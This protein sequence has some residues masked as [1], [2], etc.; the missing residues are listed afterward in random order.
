MR[1]VVQVFASAFRIRKIVNDGEFCIIYSDK[2]PNIDF[3]CV[4]DTWIMNNQPKVGGYC[5]I[6]DNSEMEYMDEDEFE[7]NSE[8]QGIRQEKTGMMG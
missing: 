7:M 5:V 1:Y 8:Q 2:D 4:T 3:L 6:Y